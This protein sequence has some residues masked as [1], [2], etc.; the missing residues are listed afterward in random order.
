MTTATAATTPGGATSPRRR[1]ARFG[2]YRALP[3]GHVP[4]VL[5]I[6]DH[7]VNLKLVAAQ[8]AALGATVRTASSGEEGLRLWRSG[9]YDAV[10]TD[11]NMGDMD[12]YTL[13]AAIRAF[14]Q[15]GGH[16]HLPVVGWTVSAI[17]ETRDACHAAG[18]DAV[19][20]KPVSL[21]ALRAAL[22]TWFPV[23]A[24]SGAD[25]FPASSTDAMMPLDPGALTMLDD[26]DAIVSEF[27]AQ[28][29]AD[30]R[31]LAAALQGGD[32]VRAARVLHRLRGASLMVG[33][34]RLA[35]SCA[36]MP[37]ETDSPH[38]AVDAVEVI[39]R[40]LARIEEYTL[41]QASP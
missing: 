8:L 30:A 1:P 7:P 4:Y 12:G 27:L 28:A 26:A 22:A 15:V 2:T 29:H 13:C 24:A 25:A 34:E 16:P 6:D 37:C 35:A 40:E 38:D 14:E 21:E 10:I 17:A 33:A 11:C 41:R 3:P 23:L 32:A 39:E 31:E 5:A 36:G 9:E 18:M 20:V 19:L